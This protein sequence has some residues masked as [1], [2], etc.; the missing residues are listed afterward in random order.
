M[1]QRRYFARTVET[2]SRRSWVANS[3]ADFRS[4]AEPDLQTPAKGRATVR[5]LRMNLDGCRRG[6]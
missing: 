2:D 5:Q 1:D 6:A 3:G 4:R